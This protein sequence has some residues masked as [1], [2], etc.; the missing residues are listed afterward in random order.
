MPLKNVKPTSP[1]RRG[2]VLPSFEEIT[3]KKP[4]RSLLLPLRKKGGRNAQ[5]PPDGA[6]PRRRLQAKATRHRLQAR[7][8]WRAGARGGNRVR[9]QPLGPHRPRVLRGRRQ[10]VQP[11]AQRPA[12]RGHHSGRPERGHQRGQRPAASPHPVGQHRPQRGDAPRR[13]RQDGKGSGHV[14]AGSRTRGEPRA[15][16]DALRRGPPPEP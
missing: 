10:A 12:S 11:G 1:G 5:G 9:P 16:S 6:S 4:E 3:K 15:A 13:R 8:G 2:V 7:Q 14:G